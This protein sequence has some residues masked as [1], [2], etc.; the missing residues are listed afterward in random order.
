MQNFLTYQ[1]V[2]VYPG[3]SLNCVVGP[4]G[5]GKSSL[6][7]AICLGLAGKPSS[8]GRAEKVG[9]FIRHGTDRSV[10]EIDLHAAN[11]DGST[12]TIRR[13][14][15]RAGD[16]GSAQSSW[17]L[18]G[19]SSTQGAVNDFVM[20]LHIQ[21]DNICVLLAQERVTTFATL[22]PKELLEHTEK[23]IDPAL[24]EMH[25]QLSN[26]AKKH[27]ALRL[28]LEDVRKRLEKLKAANK[29]I[30]SEVVR[31]DRKKKMKILVEVLEK[32]LL[33][34]QRTLDKQAAVEAQQKLAAKKD[35]LENISTDL[36]PI[37]SAIQV[38][39]KAL[40]KVQTGVDQSKKNGM[41]LARQKTNI[42]RKLEDHAGTVSELETEI[43]SLRRNLRQIQARIEKERERR[44]KMQEELNALPNTEDRKAQLD[45]IDR[46]MYQLR[47]R[48]QTVQNER[49]D[50]TNRMQAKRRD[51][52]RKSVQLKRF[53]DVKQ[54]RFSAGTRQFHKFRK[55]HAF[56]EE[57]KTRA[58]GP[59]H[60]P[61]FM[62]I[63]VP[64]QYAKQ[65]ENC[66]KFAHKF[67]WVCE[68][69]VDRNELS[70]QNINVSAVTQLEEN[71]QTASHARM[72]QQLDAEYGI[73]TVDSVVECHP[74]IRNILVKRNGFAL[75][76]VTDREIDD[77]ESVLEKYPQISNLYTPSRN[78]TIK[79]SRYASYSSVMHRPLRAAILLVG[80]DQTEERQEL[81]DAYNACKSEVNDL[82]GKLTHHK[83][84]ERDLQ[85]RMRHLQQEKKKFT[86]SEKLRRGLASK[87][88]TCDKRIENLEASL[89]TAD[90]E[91][92]IKRDL[93]GENKRRGK[94][95]GHLALL[96]K[97][98]M[99]NDASM[100]ALRLEHAQRTA[101]IAMLTGILEQRDGARQRLMDEVE[102]LEQDFNE[103][104]Q[105][106][107][108]SLRRRDQEAPK[109]VWQA[110]FTEHKED[111]PETLDEINGKIAELSAQIAHINPNDRVIKE[112][113]EREKQIVALTADVERLD[114]EYTH[115]M[116][117]LSGV[118]NAYMSQI[119]SKVQIIGDAF[120]AYFRAMDCEGKVELV[121][122]EDF[123]NY[124]LQILVKYRAS[125]Q[126]RPLEGHFQSGGEKSVATMLFLLC[127]QRVTDT[128]FRVVD[129]INQ[130]M[131]AANERMIF[132]QIVSS[133][134]AEELPQYF[135]VTPKLLPNLRY[136]EHC[137]VLSV[138]NGPYNVAQTEW[139][140]DSLL[141][142]APKATKYL[143]NRAHR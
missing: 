119:E 33:W 140:W 114:A 93:A 82:H 25:Q 121:C 76:L 24:Y 115:V 131:D 38:E 12:A 27:D 73:K 57:Y 60:G 142:Q 74:T 99:Q 19:R 17:T 58:R 8:I 50:I 122:H 138:F 126:L 64:P 2:Q 53:S 139:N 91:A 36:A 94:T 80:T 112:Y 10:V 117:S 66:M 45:E 133:S 78:V 85:E 134:S 47:R 84:I 37:H 125:A 83:E 110:K 4:N 54:V 71:K 68:N 26:G 132:D 141:Q 6:V 35:E 51:A 67:M 21:V 109:R 107:R 96:M 29:R 30:Q 120:S 106:A 52:E 123:S 97:Q 70:G 75:S 56:V 46:E 31:L 88:R 95:L 116:D 32:R 90:R 101:K 28:E 108:I 86:S 98:W 69:V 103:K 48:N 118:K 137:T 87:I 79:K 62:D 136:N 113:Y 44:A 14:I 41:K 42:E 81:L 92:E 39:Q 7:C 23:A 15:T 127:L 104:I 18:N 128:P 72:L 105:T 59:I 49:I 124:E 43:S 143:S 63:K 130:G 11:A 34:V 13:T 20:K 65:V 89:N 100:I 16:D 61:M 135:L 5:T 22:K 40:G 111:I 1:H 3:P 9:Q 102:Q 77:I 55:Q 129:E